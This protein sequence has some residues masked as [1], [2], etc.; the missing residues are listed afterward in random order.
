MKKFFAVLAVIALVGCNRA[1]N[2]DIAC[3]AYDI[4]MTF[5]DNGDTLHA[6]INGDDVTL[7]NDISASGA[8]YIGTYNDSEITLW[9]K[10]NDWTMFIDDGDAIFCK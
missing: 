3:G 7:Y 4:N 2:I 6:R 5:S 9:S 1:N 10:G 8:R